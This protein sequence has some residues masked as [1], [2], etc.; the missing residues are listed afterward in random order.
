MPPSLFL[1]YAS[2]PESIGRTVDA[3][4]TY[5]H[6]RPQILTAI[7][8]KESPIVGKFV[9]TAVRDQITNA[10]FL[11][12]DISVANFNVTYEIG[13]AIGKG[14]P[15]LLIRN[16]ALRHSK[17]PSL[18]TLGIFDTLGYKNY[19]NSQ[20]L[21]A[22]L[23][24]S[25]DI[26]P[27]G[28]TP[29]LSNR[30]TPVYLLEAKYKTEAVT[31]IIARVK[32][33][34]LFYRSFDPQ[35]TPRL[36]AFE[37]IEQVSQSYGVLVH[38]LPAHIEDAPLHNL[39]AAFL[40][41]LADGFDKPLTI[42]QDGDEP[43]PLD[44]RDLVRAF[45]HPNQIDEIVA[46]FGTRVTE[47]IQREAPTHVP[48]PETLLQRL[49]IG[50]S[51]AENE[52]RNLGT[53]YL[54][55]DAF[56]RA[57]RGEVRLVV[58]RKGSGKSALFF[59]LRDDLRRHRSNLVLDLKPEGYKLLKF[60]EDVLNLLSAGTL[61]H[62]VTA[63]WEYLLLLEIC[64]KLLSGDR[65]WHTRDH[66]LYQPYRKL[67]ELFATDAFVSE[68]DFS[69]RMTLL[70]QRISADYAEKFGA[71]PN[72]RLSEP[73]LTELLYRHDVPALRNAV[74]DYLEF[75]E[76]VWVLFDN[77]DKGWPTH[78]LKHEDLLIVRC[79]LDATRD[80]E[81]QLQR[82]QIDFETVVFLRNDVFELLI[83]ETPDRGKEARVLVDWTDP[84][85]LRELLRRRLVS[86]LPSDNTFS[87][88][89]NT[90]CVSLVEGEESSQ[91][92][93][94][95]S[96]MRPRALLNLF[97]HCRS[98]AVNLGH[99][100]I[101]EEDI[102]KGLRAYSTDLVYDIGLE[103]RDIFPE[104]ED[105]LY[106][107][108]ESPATLPDPELHDLLAN[109]DLDASKFDDVIELLLWFGVLGVVR[110]QSEVTYIFNVNYDMHLLNG[111][112]KKLRNK[113]LVYHINPAF[114]AALDI[115][116]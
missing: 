84:D 7:T 64:N 114:W 79:L 110:A 63:F 98:N 13:Y 44:Y 9:A 23:E 14:K 12:A 30:S 103:I 42:L 116:G 37:A 35:E 38:L 75:K 73:Q 24:T 56:H 112:A 97:T 95:R 82:R 22:L 43:V 115:K 90:I 58:G 74:I 3:A 106:V 61:E 70:L 33:A 27:L 25:T 1:A 81:R 18:E 8:W 54:Q 113:G 47:A 108:I 105:A 100:R 40:A 102:R 99:P 69:E 49:S 89:W 29:V 94:D 78:G 101:G 88:L 93:I 11:I 67:S 85:L 34:R 48:E 62:T 31:R 104:A 55:T 59:Q 15:L 16:P 111:I 72:R 53:Y 20:E 4:A 26:A 60:K 45:R 57:R 76:G 71:Q 19:Q 41:G 17:E 10:D 36:S 96:L 107:F 83:E 92:L 65:T 86:H 6:Q 21:I 2:D 87:E 91:Y 80:L 5:F 32:K 46:E 68:G 39:R 51:S 77:L 52:I 66:H 50:A 28:V 109:S